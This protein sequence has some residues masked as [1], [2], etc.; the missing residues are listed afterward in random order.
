MVLAAIVFAGYVAARG[1]N[2][3]GPESWLERGWGRLEAG[4]D[5]DHFFGTAQLGVDWTPNEHFDLHISGVGRRDAL[6]TDAGIV[7][8]YADV[9]TS[10]ALD[11][12]QLRAG[13]FFLPTSRENKDELWTSPYTISFSA[14]NSWIG[15]EVRPIGVDLQYRHTTSRGHAITTA[16]T[17]FRGNDSM[18]ALLAWR[19]WA[20]GNRLSTYNEVLPLPPL[21]TLDELFPLQRKDGTKPFGTDLDGRTGYSAR[22]R[23]AVPQRVNV[24]YTYLDNRGDRELHRGEYAWATK[25]HL[26]GIEAGNPDRLAVAGEYMRGSTTMGRGVAFVDA[27]FFAAYLLVSG[28]GGRNRLTARYELFNTEE[29][30]FSVAELNEENGRSWTL[31][32]MFDITPPLRIGAELTQVVGDR[33]DTPDP[34]AR[35]VTLE[36]RWRF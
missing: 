25:F 1:V 34:D 5:R 21:P 28:K 11:E 4:G 12:V 7:E 20:I 22:V 16:A 23:Y 14:L 27:D 31:T 35:T 29:Q 30:D 6:G 15:E 33:A 13:Q 2:A 19:G 32:W 17:A 26:F 9:R 8:A 10:F 18:G 36:A 24:L 3:T